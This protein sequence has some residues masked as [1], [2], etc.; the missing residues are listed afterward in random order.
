[1]YC[2]NNNDISSNFL[3]FLKFSSEASIL[4]SMCD[5]DFPF[6]RRYFSNINGEDVRKWIVNNITKFHNNPTINESVV[7]GFYGKKKLRCK[8]YFSQLQ[9]VFV[10]FNSE[11]VRKWVPNP[12]LK[13][14]DDPKWIIPRSS[15]LQGKREFW[16]EKKEKKYKSWGTKYLNWHI[17]I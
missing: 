7:L 5:E 3:R 15:F 4:L 11:N 2:D 1:M 14:Y 9:C 6:E 17:F 12:V 8:G 16:E 10:F 13:F